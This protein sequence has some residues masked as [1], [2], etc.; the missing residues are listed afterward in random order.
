MANMAKNVQFD[1]TALAQLATTSD[2]ATRRNLIVAL[3]RMADS[4]ED[5][6]GTIHR[7]GHIVRCCHNLLRDAR[8]CCVEVD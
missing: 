6:V 4:L 2:R 5:T 1:E 7:Y 8:Y 3:R